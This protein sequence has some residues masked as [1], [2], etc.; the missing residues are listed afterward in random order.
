MPPRG[1]ETIDHTAD[2]GIRGWGGTPAEAFEEAA[3][4]MLDLAADRSVLAASASVRFRRGAHDL[5]GLLL[6]FLNALIAEADVAGLVLADAAVDALSGEDGA[7]EIEATA[8][9]V[10]AD[11]AREALLVEVKAAT[12]CGAFVRRESDGRWIAQCVVDL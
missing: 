2:M 12:S 9:G 8:R 7:W 6:E 5:T 4:A 11:E 3:A 10:P 1:H